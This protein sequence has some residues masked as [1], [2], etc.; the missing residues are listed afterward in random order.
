MVEVDFGVVAGEGTGRVRGGGRE[1]P[2][3]DGV[4][5]GS[6]GRGRIGV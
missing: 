3:R 4:L 2:G 6:S 1:G 5:G